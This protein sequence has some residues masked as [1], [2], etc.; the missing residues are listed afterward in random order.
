MVTGLMSDKSGIERCSLKRIDR[1]V[2]F[3]VLQ[4]A[5]RAVPTLAF[6]G[7]RGS[8]HHSG[9]TCLDDFRVVVVMPELAGDAFSQQ[10]DAL[11]GKS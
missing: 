5:A 2:A 11:P 7:A 4:L 10:H 8:T 3:H 1:P 9:W 6:A